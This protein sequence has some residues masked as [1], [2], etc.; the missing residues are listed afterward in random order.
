[1]AMLNQKVLHL[2]YVKLELLQKVHLLQLME[3]S[4]MNYQMD[5]S[6]IV[7]EPQSFQMSHLVV[8]MMTRKLVQKMLLMFYQKLVEIIKEP[9]QM[10]LV[11]QE[12]TLQM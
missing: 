8:M 10:R 1:M 6:V 12:L 5:H 4:Q 9:F 7:K 3:G 2:E 11:V